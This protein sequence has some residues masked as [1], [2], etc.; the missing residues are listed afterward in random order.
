[1]GREAHCICEWNGEAARVKALLEPPE[2]ILRGEIRRK[3]PLAQIEHL[4]AEGE[5]LSF[6]FGP[7]KICLE[8]GKALALKWARAMLAPPPTLAKKLGIVS[9]SNVRIIGVIDDEALR[10]AFRDAK[11][12]GRGKADFTLARVNTPA[13]L[14]GAFS[15]QADPAKAGAPIWIVYRKGRGHAIN[16]SDARSCGLDAGFV[17]VKVAAVSTELTALKFVRR[18]SPRTK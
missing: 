5:W 15:K 10:E 11:V 12:V 18:K 7:D 16:E 13:E 4:S 8:L 14:A 9:G 2:L 17:D 6:R 1:M 3:I